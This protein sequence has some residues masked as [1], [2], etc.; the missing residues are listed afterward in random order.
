MTYQD[1]NLTAEY[2]NTRS[3]WDRR[4]Y[5]SPYPEQWEFNRRETMRELSGAA[6]AALNFLSQVQDEA[7]F[8]T[9]MMAC[10]AE[11]P[12]NSTDDP[13]RMAYTR[14]P[15]DG[16]NERR[17]KTSVGKWF[18]KVLPGCFGGRAMDALIAAHKIHDRELIELD[19]V[20]AMVEHMANS[21]NMSCR[22]GSCMGYRFEGRHPYQVYDPA[23][24]WKMVLMKQGLKIKGRCLVNNGKFVRLYGN[25]SNEIQAMMQLMEAKGYEY[26]TGWFDCKIKK[27]KHSYYIIGPYIDGNANK[28]IDCGDMI[29]LVDDDG[30]DYEFSN[31]SGYAEK[32][33]PEDN[34]DDQVQTDDGDWIDEDDAY[35]VNGS[36]YHRDDIVF[37]D[38]EPQLESECVCLNNGDWCLREDAV[39]IQGHWYDKESDDICYDNVNGKFILSEDAVGLENGDMIHT[40]D[41]V[42]I[43]SKGYYVKTCEAC[44]MPDGEW[45]EKSDLITLRNGQ[46]EFAEKCTEIDGNWY[47]ISDLET[48]SSLNVNGPFEMAVTE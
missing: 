22:F 37:V 18:S 19:T 13:E 23:L 32:Y 46:Y 5:T 44:E 25:D 30:Y 15:E 28:G 43:D 45:Y 11:W 12:C 17:T 3:V 34:H 40:D 31:T 41:A 1:L 29:E 8:E 36:W 24:G 35:R 14:S 26:K 47:R 9:L 33:E 2:I 7:N 4:Y 48:L 16:A 42:Y 21:E 27:I 39:R 6:L 38:D 10:I 20:E